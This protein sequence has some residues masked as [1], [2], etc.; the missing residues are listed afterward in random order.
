MVNARLNQ[1]EDSIERGEKGEKRKKKNEDCR[2]K[3]FIETDKKKLK[4]KVSVS[5]ASDPFCPSK[6]A[7]TERRYYYEHQS[8][9]DLFF[10]KS[11]FRRRFKSCHQT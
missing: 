7:A 5:L 3:L 11:Q 10:D 8:Q 2:G 6:N 9:S 1:M 4:C